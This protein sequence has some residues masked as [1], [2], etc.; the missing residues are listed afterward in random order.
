MYS[1]AL[2][3][4]VKSYMKFAK[5]CWVFAFSGDID[6]ASR[7]HRYTGWPTTEKFGLIEVKQIGYVVRDSCFQISTVHVIQ[8]QIRSLVVAVVDIIGCV[9]SAASSS[10]VMCRLYF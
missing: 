8:C 3:A 2:Q 7:V 5:P 9:L 10:E 1:L 6:V 4:S